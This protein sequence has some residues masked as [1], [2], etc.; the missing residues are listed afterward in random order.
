MADWYKIKRILVWQNWVEKQIRPS[1]YN[2]QPTANTL[3]YYPFEDNTTDAKWNTSL[4]W[5]TYT[6]QNIWYLC[7]WNSWST[8]NA[9]TASDSIKSW[10]LTM[11]SW[12]NV[13]NKGSSSWSNW[14]QVMFMPNGNS[15]YCYYLY[16]IWSNLFFSRTSNTSDMYTWATLPTN[17]WHLL[18]LKV[19]SSWASWY[20][21][22]TEYPIFSWYGYWA[23]YENIHLWR[24]W[25][26]VI[27]SHVIWEN[28]TRTTQEIQNYYNQ[29]KSYFWL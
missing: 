27:H 23:W 9:I 22:G 28:R 14:A 2:W 3:F 13:Q 8:T 4:S 20:I 10:L 5:G 21:D 15:S 26:Q 6:K 7:A 29:T 12:V 24:S 1:W 19:S 17:S 25:T 18:V 11:L 16:S